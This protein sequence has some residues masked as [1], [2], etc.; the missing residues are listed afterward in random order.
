MN[1]TSLK[2]GVGRGATRLGEVLQTNFLAAASIE[3]RF[4]G[5]ELFNE[6]FMEWKAVGDGGNL[7]EIN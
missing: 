4:N 6:L 3:I 2:W 5:V 1:S 7:A